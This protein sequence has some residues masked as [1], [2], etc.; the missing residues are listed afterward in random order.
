MAK[1]KAKSKKRASG[2]EEFVVGSTLSK[3]SKPKKKL[4]DDGGSKPKK[5]KSKDRGPKKLGLADEETK[6][7]RSGKALEKLERSKERLAKTL[8]ADSYK[9]LTKR[10]PPGEREYLEEYVWMFHRVGR[11][12]RKLEKQAMKSGQARDVYALNNM[13]SQQREI[14][15]DIRTLADLSG[16]MNMIRENVLQPVISNIAQNLIDSYYHIRR[17][18]VE[19]CEPK[20]TEFAL[21]QLQTIVQEQ[22]KYLQMQ[23][24]TGCEQLDRV[25]AGPEEPAKGK[26][27]KKKAKKDALEG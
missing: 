6:K 23:Y 20:Q 12:I 3:P 14:I 21:K 8:G 17:L 10:A 19:T 2:D 9:E 4:K 5:K 1:D 27:K 25:M 7:E 22:S 18:M 13:I 26:K 24:Q 11:L 16:Q 15:A